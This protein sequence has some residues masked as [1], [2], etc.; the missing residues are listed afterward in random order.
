MDDRFTVFLSLF[1][2]THDWDGNI[3][4]I[5][6]QKGFKALCS[7]RKV[8]VLY[9]CHW[10]IWLWSR[11]VEPWRNVRNL[12]VCAKQRHGCPS[13]W[14]ACF[15][16]GRRR[17]WISHIVSTIQTCCYMNR[18][19]GLLDTHDL[20]WAWPQ[21]LV[22]VKSIQSAEEPLHP[23]LKCHARRAFQSGGAKL[24]IANNNTRLQHGCELLK[25]YRKTGQAEIQRKKSQDSVNMK[26]KIS[27]NPAVQCQHRDGFTCYSKPVPPIQQLVR[28][29]VRKSSQS[30]WSIQCYDYRTHAYGIR[31]HRIA[32]AFS[33]DCWGVKKIHTPVGPWYGWV[34]GKN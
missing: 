30:C 4:V 17:G 14:T 2:C 6:Y 9:L 5:H 27:S 26:T 23:A 1:Q 7:W 20:I 34:S 25:R 15:S 3:T 28:P 24:K 21:L 12:M 19:T 29:E 33:W 18:S 10:A 11:E 22:F 13:A 16:V 31:I 8:N 32:T